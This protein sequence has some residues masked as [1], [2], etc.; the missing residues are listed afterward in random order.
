MV[1]HTPG[2][3][4]LLKPPEN[5]NVEIL[6]KIHCNTHSAGLA[7]FLVEAQAMAG[8][9][10]MAVSASKGQQQHMLARAQAACS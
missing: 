2:R 7:A 5:V 3:H 4:H 1:E 10:M 9:E 8:R 6:R